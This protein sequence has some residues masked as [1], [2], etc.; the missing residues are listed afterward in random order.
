ME[1]C[2]WFSYP[3]SHRPN[4]GGAAQDTERP[5]LTQ[6][7]QLQTQVRIRIPASHPFPST[8]GPGGDLPQA[9]PQLSERSG[10][11]AAAEGHPSPD[12]FLK[13]I[14]FSE[15]LPSRDGGRAGEGTAAGAVLTSRSWRRRAASPSTRAGGRAQ[16]AGGSA[17][18]P[19]SRSK[20]QGRGSPSVGKLES[21][22]ERRD[23]KLEERKAAAEWG[24][25]ARG[26]GRWRAAALLRPRRW[27]GVP[28]GSLGRRQVAG[29][30]RSG[31]WVEPSGCGAGRRRGSCCAPSAAGL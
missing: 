15:N 22:T 8:S 27:P 20:E 31:P 16:A 30:W 24:A 18:C 13:G 11:A 21:P 2:R 23:G 29:P 1:T 28:R 26:G 3:L 10:L 6:G 7:H 12:P 14:L 9:A 5:A 19:S 17:G 4:A 25:E